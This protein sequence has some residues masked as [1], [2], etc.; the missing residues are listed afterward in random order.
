MVKSFFLPDISFRYNL[1]SGHLLSALANSKRD[2]D[3]IGFDIKSLN[4]L[5]TKKYT[6]PIS[7]E[8]YRER[9]R[10]NQIRKCQFC[11]SKQFNI[12]VDDEGNETKEYFDT[13]TEIPEQEIEIFSVVNELF[14]EIISHEK[15]T[16]QWLCPKCSSL[17]LISKTPL[18]SKAW[19]SNSTFGVIWDKPVKTFLNRSQFDKLSMEWVTVFQREIDVAMMAYQKAYFD[20]HGEAMS[21]NINSFSHDGGRN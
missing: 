6:I 18:S 7:T 3:I 14:V 15:F 10:L 21:N 5:L 4:T 2:W 13:Q 16:R 9:T 17:N 19:D 11:F 1:Y 8:L 20:E 12:K